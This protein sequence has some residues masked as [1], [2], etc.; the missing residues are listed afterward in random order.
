MNPAVVSVYANHIAA[1]VVD[2]FRPRTEPYRIRPSSGVNCAAIPF[3]VAAGAKPNVDLTPPSLLFATGHFHHNMIYAALHS[4]LPKSAIS[5]QDET[6]VLLPDWWP[7]NPDV[8]KQVGHRDL[9]ISVLEKGWLEEHLPQTAT[10]DIKTKH[11]LGQH[12]VDK[13]EITALEDVFGNGAQVA[14]YETNEDNDGYIFYSNREVPKDGGRKQF[15]GKRIWKEDLNEIRDAVKWRVSMTDEF[16]PEIWLGKNRDKTITCFTPCD[17]YCDFRTA[18][19]AK[20]VEEKIE[21]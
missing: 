12:R 17:R 5:V 10:W 6:E 16:V 4:A 2:S 9:Y 13:E 15:K 20:R 19:Y 14:I 7:K 1:D 3:L 18:C 11:A 8:F 21:V